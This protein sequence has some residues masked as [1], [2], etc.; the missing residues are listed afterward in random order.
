[1]A[2]RLKAVDS[3]STRGP[4]SPLVGSNPTLSAIACG[5][6]I[7][8]PGSPFFL[9]AIGVSVDEVSFVT[10]RRN[11]FGTKT[12][13]SRPP[14]NSCCRKAGNRIKSQIVAG[15]VCF[16]V[17]SIRRSG[18]VVEGGRLESVC[19]A[20]YRGFKSLLLRQILNASKNSFLWDFGVH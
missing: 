10:I 5:R 13:F 6:G 1:M 14:G 2:E 12:F 15:E 8:I 20:R 19:T 3:K 7:R 4:K 9:R 11:A 16:L 17:C 18:R